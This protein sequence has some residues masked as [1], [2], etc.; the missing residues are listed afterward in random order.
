M[1]NIAK[2]FGSIVG[3]GIISL[4]WWLCVKFDGCG[5]AKINR[6]ISRTT[7]VQKL[8]DES[9][10]KSVQRQLLDTTEHYTKSNII[11]SKSEV[12][13]TSFT[14]FLQHKIDSI[15]KELDIKN[16]QITGLKSELVNAHGKI[17]SSINYI[18]DNTYEIPFS[19]CFLNGYSVINL[20]D[21]TQEM[22][23]S[24]H[25]SI[26]EVDHIHRRY[27]ILFLHFGKITIKKDSWTNCPNVQIDS[28]QDIRIIKD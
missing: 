5:H 16:E 21:K 12:I 15:A 23:Y 14:I 8:Q 1:K 18:G 10:L 22:K 17:E 6:V 2:I 7:K 4:I 28:I 25:L 19:D 26:S 20:S 3:I 24:A 13:S 9:E 27:N 11:H